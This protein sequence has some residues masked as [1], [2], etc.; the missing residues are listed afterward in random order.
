MSNKR[1][2]ANWCNR[3][4]WITFDRIICKNGYKV[5]AFDRY[6]PDY[7]LGHLSTSIYKK[8]VEFIFGDIRDFD[9]VYKA[10]KKKYH[11]TISCFNRNSLFS[12]FTF[13]LYKNQY[14]RDL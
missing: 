6:N 3:V 7:N 2:L 1:V 4:H 9:S 14:R 10:A 12:L 5:T 8:E 13:S 11:F